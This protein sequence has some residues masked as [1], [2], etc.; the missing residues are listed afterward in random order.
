MQPGQNA[1]HQAVAGADS[2][3]KD[4]RRIDRRLS[5]ARS[6]EGARAFVAQRDHHELAIGACQQVR[7]VLLDILGAV[8]RLE[9]FLGHLHH[10]GEV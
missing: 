3:T 1:R 8:E 9:I 6:G 10:M 4:R 7:C 5:L 2:V